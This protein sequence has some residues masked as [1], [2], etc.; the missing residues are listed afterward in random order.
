LRA[1]LIES[2]AIDNVTLGRLGKM[3]EQHCRRHAFSRARFIIDEQVF[4]D[5]SEVGIPIVPEEADRAG[6]RSLDTLPQREPLQ[7]FDSVAS[8]RPPWHALYNDCCG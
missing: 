1:D 7:V 2:F 4:L 3:Y 5:D 6:R 8:H